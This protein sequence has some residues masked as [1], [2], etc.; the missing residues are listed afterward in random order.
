MV[1]EGGWRGCGRANT[2]DGDS[3][4][5]RSGLLGRTPYVR[6]VTHIRCAV[7]FAQFTGVINLTW[8]N[9]LPSR[10]TRFRLNW[11]TARG[12]IST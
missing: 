1:E 10:V 2:G 12:G 3:D 4:N 9:M 5:T 8:K 11:S 6:H 7:R